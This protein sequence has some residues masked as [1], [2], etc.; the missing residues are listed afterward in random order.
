[1]QQ[2]LC[3]LERLKLAYDWKRDSNSFVVNTRFLSKNT[4]KKPPNNINVICFE[5]ARILCQIK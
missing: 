5:E 2:F 1:M 3:Q 4:T